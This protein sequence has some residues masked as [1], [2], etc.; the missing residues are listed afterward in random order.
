MGFSDLRQEEVCF[1]LLLKDREVER[2]G[3]ND[4]TF[5]IQLP[6]L[7]FRQDLQSPTVQIIVIP[8]HIAVNIERSI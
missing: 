4:A 5:S 7:H 2:K 8:I 3:G 6:C 1:L